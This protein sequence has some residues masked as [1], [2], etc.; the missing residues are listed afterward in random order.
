MTDAHTEVLPR[1]VLTCFGA[2]L[3]YGYFLYIS[4]SVPCQQG[5]QLGNA[6][7]V[8]MLPVGEAVRVF[9]RVRD[10]VRMRGAAMC[11]RDGMGVRVGMRMCERVDHNADGSGE[12][13][14]QRGEKSDCQR[15]MEQHEREKHADERRGGVIALVF[16]APRLLCARIYVK[17]LSP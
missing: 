4:A 7:R 11:V 9:M 3:L 8:R 1:S 6:V 15:L 12:H 17:M 16:A 13:H 5:F 10:R 14:E 2:K